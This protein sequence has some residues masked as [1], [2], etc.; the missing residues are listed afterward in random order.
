MEGIVTQTQQGLTKDD[1]KWLA[2]FLDE[3]KQYESDDE[4]IEFYEDL[5]ARI[6]V[7]YEQTQAWNNQP[8]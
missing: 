5:I 2:N 7:T 3:H 6:G 1:L 8:T 4:S